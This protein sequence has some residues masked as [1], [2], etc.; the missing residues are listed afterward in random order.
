MRSLCSSL[1]GIWAFLAVLFW[2]APGYAN[3][4]APPSYVWLRFEGARSA[5]QG[6]QLAE[7]H[8]QKCTQPILL[9]QSGTCADADCLK[10]SP[11]LSAPHRFDCAS[12]ACLFVEPSF[13][14]R[15]SGPYY[16]LI[17]Q[18][19]DRVRTSEAVVLTIKNDLAGYA[20]RN[21]RVKVQVNDLAIVPD[22]NPMKPS[23]WEVFGNA[24]A[25]TEISELAVATL[26]L[27]RMNVEKQQAG[28]GLVAIA[29]VNL[30]TFPVVWFFFPALQPFQ[31]SASRVFGV[32][33]LG[34]AG[35][36]GVLLASR[37]IVTLKTL[38]TM[39]I[40]WLLSLPTAFVIGIIFAFILGYGESLPPVIGVS[41][42]ITLP[43]S[44]IFAVVFE[45]WLI[46]R[47]NQESISR[48][49]ASLLS[50]TMNVSSMILGLWLLPAT[51]SF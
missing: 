45:A 10:S 33:I 40:G 14:P 37:P 24:L 21:L 1:I 51:Q 26:W 12:D 39:F 36:F 13:S 15:S 46:Y 44:E 20:A 29:F 47:S 32:M 22:T 41:S 16:K 18:F 28:K 27:W 3:A 9:M 8:T 43:A 11:I 4:P 6:A 17:A 38:R 23:R 35:L 48:R 5:F 7:C 25:L 42:L 50:L 34:V 30:L 31:Y 19:S 2:A 49:Q